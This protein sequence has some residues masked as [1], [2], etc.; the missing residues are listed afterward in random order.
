MFELA[1]IGGGAAGLAAAVEAGAQARRANTDV[2]IAVYEAI[3]RVGRPILVSG[4]G[5]CNFSNAHIAP[6]CYHN[7][8]F[9]AEAF[10]ALPPQQVM[11]FFADCGL[12]WR[13]EG[14]G[15]LY[16]ATLKASTVLDVLRARAAAFGVEERCSTP[17]VRIEGPRQPGGRFTLTA[18]DGAFIRADAVI[19]AV[20]G[21]AGLAMLPDCVPTEPQRPVLGALRTDTRVV[22]AL[23]NIRARCAIHL[24]DGATGE[25]KAAEE[26]ELLFRKYG[27]SG[28][29]VFNLSRFAVEGD[30]LSIDLLPDVPGA[31]D[32]LAERAARLACTGAVDTLGD[33]FRGLLLPR[34][35]DAVLR[36][37]EVDPQTKAADADPDAFARLA[38]VA[39]GLRLTVREVGAADTSQV[40]RGGVRVDAVG[41]ETMEVAGMPGLHIVG[42]L[43]DVDGPCG[44]Y[45]LHWAWTTGLLAARHAVA[46]LAQHAAA[47]AGQD[48][49]GRAPHDR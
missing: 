43:L 16:P 34:L 32:A 29:A 27:V 28:I 36:E 35:A 38:A 48:S 11:D 7:A 22:Q 23:D 25:P 39:K 40:T 21:K 13:E 19:V 4:N 2:S 15:R 31:A 20:G 47:S 26:G 17:I 14:Q 42:E 46:S 44:G 45:N 5:R 3:D 30:V 9:V 18:K 37:A 12:V 1:I 6:D 49:R 8:S 33:L 41:P 24:L 10:A